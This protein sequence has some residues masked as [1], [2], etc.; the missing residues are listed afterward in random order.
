MMQS[1]VHPTQASATVTHQSASS[2]KSCLCWGC[3]TFWSAATHQ[4]MIYFCLE[5][6]NIFQMGVS[7]KQSAEPSGVSSA[8]H[9]GRLVN[10]TCACAAMI[11]GWKPRSLLTWKKNGGGKGWGGEKSRRREKGDGRGE[12]DQVSS[13]RVTSA[14]HWWGRQIP[15][16][17]LGASKHTITEEKDEQGFN[18]GII[19]GGP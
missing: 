7:Q 8:C 5:T 4:P 13:S 19:T 18:Q 14:S 9:A 11:C 17:R 16:D 2:R 12:K 6:L 15:L 3:L 1:C 10:P